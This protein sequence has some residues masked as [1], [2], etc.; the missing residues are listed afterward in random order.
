MARITLAPILGSAAGKLKNVVFMPWRNTMRM[1]TRVKPHNPQSAAQTLVRGY[2]KNWTKEW[3][4]LTLP[5]IANWNSQ[6]TET[7]VANKDGIK[8]KTTGKNMFCGWNNENSLVGDGLIVDTWFSPTV[9]TTIQ[10]T[11]IDFDSVLLKATVTTGAAVPPN[12]LLQIWATPPL[13]GGVSS[14]GKKLTL[15]KTF[16][17]GTAGGNLDIYAAY[18]GKYGL[19]SAGKMVCVQAYLNNADSP[20]FVV[21]FKAGAEL[22]G[23]VK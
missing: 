6:A 11:A 13:G 23:R 12:S 21:K 20:K 22:A 16:V 19:L 5:Q 14:Y 2:F 7:T 3:S 17:A 18:T 15:I 9:P 10:V 8:V 4:N 1:R